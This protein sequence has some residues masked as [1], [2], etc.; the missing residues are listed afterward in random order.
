M[1]SDAAKCQ[2][3]CSL[4][5]TTHEGS[6]MAESSGMSSSLANAGR[7]ILSRGVSN[8]TDES[9]LSSNKGGDS[10]NGTISRLQ[11]M[12]DIKD[13]EIQSL[14]RRPGGVR[15]RGGA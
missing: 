2:T 11:T 7:D 3:G 6:A 10:T 15:R 14:R 9:S 8:I 4:D 12:L 1:P 13:G 5:E